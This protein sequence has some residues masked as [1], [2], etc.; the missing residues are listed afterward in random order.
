[1]ITSRRSKEWALISDALA[2]SHKN[3]CFGKVIILPGYH[4]SFT[5]KYPFPRP[6]TCNSLKTSLIITSK[7]KNVF[8]LWFVV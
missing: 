3:I 7:N 1:L 4:T 8:L 5:E 6:K 2:T